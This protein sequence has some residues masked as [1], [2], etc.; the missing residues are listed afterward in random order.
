[1]FRLFLYL[2]THA[3][4]AISKPKLTV[5]SVCTLTADADEDSSA[6][7]DEFVGLLSDTFPDPGAPPGSSS[8]LTSSELAPHGGYLPPV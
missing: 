7:S 3:F 1:M 4:A 2:F 6:D 8:D 5:A